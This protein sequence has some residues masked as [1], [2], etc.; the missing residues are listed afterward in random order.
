MNVF[1]FNTTFIKKDKEIT[2]KNQEYADFS[3][4]QKIKSD[5]WVSALMWLL[6]HK[7]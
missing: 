3:Y 2:N 6:I 1:H 4:E 5:E 7:Y